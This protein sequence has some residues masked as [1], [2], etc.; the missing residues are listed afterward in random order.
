MPPNRLAAV[1]SARQRRPVA[2]GAPRELAN[3]DPMVE[4]I[5]SVLHAGDA[6]QACRLATQWCASHRGACD[7]DAL[8]GQLRVSV[9]P[10]TAGKNP[11]DPERIKSNKQWFLMLCHGLHQM[12]A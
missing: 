9:F 4:T 12:R 5:L 6:G 8:W 10:N 7:D 1:L 3:S 11:P 2:T